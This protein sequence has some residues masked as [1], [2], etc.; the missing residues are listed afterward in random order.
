MAVYKTTV[1]KKLL[2][3]GPP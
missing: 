3:F 1:N 2:L